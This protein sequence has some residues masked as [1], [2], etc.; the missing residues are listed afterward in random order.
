M[1]HFATVGGANAALFRDKDEQYIP[2]LVFGFSIY[3]LPFHFFCLLKFYDWWFYSKFSCQILLKAFDNNFLTQILNSGFE[4]C[5][6]NTSKEQK[7]GPCHILMW[8]MREYLCNFEKI[9]LDKLIHDDCN[10]Q[11]PKL[12]METCIWIQWQIKKRIHWGHHTKERSYE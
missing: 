5:S 6:Y 12:Q 2:Y 11:I 4:L 10:H 1:L 8:I 9:S 3:C 7:D